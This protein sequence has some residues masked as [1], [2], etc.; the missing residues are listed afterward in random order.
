MNKRFIL[1]FLSI[2][3]ISA[4]KYPSCPGGIPI[5][6]GNATD[7]HYQK[8]LELTSFMDF[9]QEGDLVPA[10]E[11][12]ARTGNKQQVESLVSHNRNFYIA[13]FS[14]LVVLSLLLFLIMIKL[15]DIKMI[16]KEVFLQI[17]QQGYSSALSTFYYL[18]AFILVASTCVL[19]YSL[20][21]M[22][23]SLQMT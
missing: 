10:F 5:D 23:S 15:G 11:E 14:I 2:G 9:Q 20:S 4:F 17:K 19:I 7:E 8:L 13:I 12:Y 1:T 3:L 22:I 18:L 16:K 6:I 21:Q